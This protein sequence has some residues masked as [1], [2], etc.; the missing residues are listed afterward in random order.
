MK[1]KR[2]LERTQA[3]GEQASGQ[4]C[5][6]DPPRIGA[7]GCRAG[8]REGSRAAGR[9]AVALKLREAVPTGVAAEEVPGA[10][11]AFGADAGGRGHG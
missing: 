8:I 3:Q 1:N 10:Q 2:R 9:G 6:K 4:V 7:E 11:T 5:L